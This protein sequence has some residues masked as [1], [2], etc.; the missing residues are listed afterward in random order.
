MVT[1]SGITESAPTTCWDLIEVNNGSNKERIVE[2][3]SAQSEP[4]EDRD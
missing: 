3:C 2:L 4:Q 1:T